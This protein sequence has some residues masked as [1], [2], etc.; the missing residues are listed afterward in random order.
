[1]QRAAGTVTIAR[2][3]GAVHVTLLFAAKNSSF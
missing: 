2:D 3:E 1:M